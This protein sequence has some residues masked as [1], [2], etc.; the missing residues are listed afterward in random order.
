MER[1]PV[2]LVDDEPVVLRMQAAAVRQFG[3]ETIIA[4]SADEGISMVRRFNPSLIVSDVQMPGR[5]GFEMLDEL[6]TRG[7]KT[8][9][10]IYMTGYDTLETVRRGLKA[11]GDDFIIK[12]E[13]VDRLRQRIAFWAT[14]GFAGLPLELRRRT[15]EA[16]YK[17]ED[18]KVRQVEAY[19]GA[20]RDLVRD[21]AAEIGRELVP[22]HPGYG[23][24]LIERI[25][26]ISRISKLVM[27]RS[28]TFGDYLR[29]PDYVFNV[30]R[31]VG[32]EWADE[33]WTILKHFDDW[34]LDPRFGR[35]G[36]SPLQCYR[37][38]S[39]FDSE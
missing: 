27:E 18:D 34:T 24:R 6:G 17:V 28:R 33:S 30:T 19:I 9:P 36:A 8:M 38:Y 13:T 14:S 3:F 29:F 7:L 37:D 32:P 35:A 2:L 12:G 20:D 21:V 31:D 22:V 11:G 4:E 16:S 10:V 23:K 39:W 1:G 15:L 26:L 25:C 5:D